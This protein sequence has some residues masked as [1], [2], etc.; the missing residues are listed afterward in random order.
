MRIQMPA[1]DNRKNKNSN[2]AVCRPCFFNNFSRRR[3]EEPAGEIGSINECASWGSAHGQGQAKTPLHRAFSTTDAQSMVA[4]ARRCDGIALAKAV[5]ACQQRG[6]PAT[7]SSAPLG[8][9]KAEKE[10]SQP[11]GRTAQVQIMVTS[12]EHK[13]KLNFRT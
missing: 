3:R 10:S 9:V 5:G 12:T 6:L 2:H 11:R 1:L 13:N 4:S 7:K 8:F